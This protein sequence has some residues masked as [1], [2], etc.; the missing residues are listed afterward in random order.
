MVLQVEI[1]QEKSWVKLI[2]KYEST[3][4][5][6]A[7]SAMT[8]KMGSHLRGNDIKKRWNDRIILYFFVRGRP[9]KSLQR[10]WRRDVFFS[11]LS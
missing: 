5:R 10:R 1:M 8:E 3:T 9:L 6:F 4:Y 2:A 7:M 11:Y